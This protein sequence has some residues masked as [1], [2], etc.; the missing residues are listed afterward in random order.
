MSVCYSSPCN[1]S[2]FYI[3]GQLNNSAKAKPTLT[4]ALSSSKFTFRKMEVILTP[5]KDFS[6]EPVTFNNCVQAEVYFSQYDKE[7]EGPKR[8][9]SDIEKAWALLKKELVRTL[10]ILL[11][12]HKEEYG[13]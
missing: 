10:E 12:L 6:S 13:S 5:L 2:K 1:F 4:R 8:S 7:E 9:S 3:P 11:N